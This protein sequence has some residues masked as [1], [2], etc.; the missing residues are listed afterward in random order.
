MTYG[1]D[2]IQ[3]MKNTEVQSYQDSHPVPVRRF[4]TLSIKRFQ[5]VTMSLL[6]RTDVHQ[7]VDHKHPAFRPSGVMNGDVSEVIA[8]T[9]PLGCAYIL[10]AYSY[11]NAGDALSESLTEKER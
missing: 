7:K 6:Q 11:Y 3:Q 2:A 4:Q 10:Y 8:K 5:E 9:G 1:T